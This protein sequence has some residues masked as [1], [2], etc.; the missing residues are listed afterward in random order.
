M[1]TAMFPTP[2]GDQS[3]ECIGLEQ[4]RASYPMQPANIAELE[5][6]AQRLEEMCESMGLWQPAAIL[7]HRVN[8]TRMLLIGEAHRLRRIAK[9]LQEKK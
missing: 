5:E 3:N 1:P 6:M 7:S 4:S 9:R 8:N 2:T